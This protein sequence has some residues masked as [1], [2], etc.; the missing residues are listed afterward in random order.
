MWLG[1]GK[2]ENLDTEKCFK[3]KIRKKKERKKCIN[4]K[5]WLNSTYNIYQPYIN[6]MYHLYDSTE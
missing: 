5:M 3:K 2:R 6:D 1:V 4:H